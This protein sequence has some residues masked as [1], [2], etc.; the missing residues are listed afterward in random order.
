MEPSCID[1]KRVGGNFTLDLSLTYSSDTP[2]TG[3]KFG[4]LIVV[5]DDKVVFKQWRADRASK[6]PSCAATRWGRCARARDC[7][8]RPGGVWNV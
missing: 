3:W 6:R 7:G 2:T 4:A 8:P 1:R 5:V